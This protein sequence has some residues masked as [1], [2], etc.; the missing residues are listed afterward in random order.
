LRCETIW[1]LC[2]FEVWNLLLYIMKYCM[3]IFS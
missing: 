3:W 2:A 1:L